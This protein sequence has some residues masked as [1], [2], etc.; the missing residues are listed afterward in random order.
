MNG[1]SEL[2]EEEQRAFERATE[3]FYRALYA[4]ESQQRRRLQNVNLPGFD[5]TVTFQSQAVDETGNTI[6]YDQTISFET[7][8]GNFR[9]E[10]A[11][12]VIVAPFE[13][14]EQAVLKLLTS[15]IFLA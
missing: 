12:E 4:E 13:E 2:N 15:K 7:N 5:T 14:E 6:L 8:P 9:E 10:E 1:A 3:D 11:R